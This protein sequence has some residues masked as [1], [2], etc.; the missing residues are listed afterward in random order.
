M[1]KVRLI[2]TEIQGLFQG[3]VT[4]QAHECGSFAYTY[5]EAIFAAAGLPVSWPQCITLFNLRR[6]TLRGMR[7][8]I[9]PQAEPKLVR[10]TARR[11]FDVAVDLWRR[12]PSFRRWVAAELSA[13]R[14]NAIY[15]P[16]GGAHGFLTLVDA[17]EVFYQM[18][19][20]YASDLAHGM[21]WNDPAFAIDWLF[22]ASLM[23]DRDVSWPDF[24]S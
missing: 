18:G 12:S 17:S 7:Y 1:K 11:V 24:A 10:C 4:V 3:E 14:C 20:S 6:G 13:E 21:R 16:P 8:Q 22:A 19:D 23:S 9:E 15:I 5:D 2:P